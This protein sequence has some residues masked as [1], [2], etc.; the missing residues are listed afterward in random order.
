[1]REQ[2][3][4]EREAM[5]DRRAERDAFREATAQTKCTRSE[6]WVLV[7]GRHLGFQSSLELVHGGGRAAGGRTVF[8]FNQF[9]DLFRIFLKNCV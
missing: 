1:M 4:I 9:L 8:V 2:R 3:D 7:D 5:R 6:A